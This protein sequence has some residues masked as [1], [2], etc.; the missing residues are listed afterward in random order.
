MKSLIRISNIELREA[1]Y[2]VDPPEHK[3]W[4]IDRWYPNVYYGKESEYTKEGDF[5]RAKGEICHTLHKSCFQHPE[6]C[7][8]IAEFI[9]NNGEYVF[10]YIGNRPL[11]LTKEEQEAFQEVIKYGFKK[12]TCYEEY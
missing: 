4:H 1:T 8:A 12:L 11:S 2:L 6:V 10:Q 9:W 7:Y 5:Y 3:A